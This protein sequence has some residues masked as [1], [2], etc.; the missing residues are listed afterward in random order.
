MQAIAGVATPRDIVRQGVKTGRRVGVAG[1]IA[2]QCKITAR[3]IARAG[4]IAKERL[5]ASGG[6]VVARVAEERIKAGGGIIAAGF[7]DGQR[8]LAGRG[9]E[10]TAG[11]RHQSG[12]AETSIIRPGISAVDGNS[13]QCKNAFRGVAVA[14]VSICPARV[15]R[16]GKAC[17]REHKQHSQ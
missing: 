15:P 7:V 16:R 10:T 13:I 6:V 11:I 14:Q 3:R 4:R 1:I 9:I 12:S 8:V 2:R 17:N 5:E